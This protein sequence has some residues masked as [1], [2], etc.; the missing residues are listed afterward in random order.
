MEMIL[1]S[2]VALLPSHTE[3]RRKGQSLWNCLFFQELCD[4]TYEIT[5]E[6]GAKTVSSLHLKHCV[7]TYDVF[8]FMREVV[9]KVPD[10]G[11]AQ[12]QGQG[13]ATMYDRSISKKRCEMPISD[14]VNDSDEEY[15]KSKTVSL[16]SSYK[17]W[18]M[19]SP[20]AGVVEGDD[21][22]EVVE[23]ELLDRHGGTATSSRQHP[24]G[25]V[26]VI[27]TREREEGCRRLHCRTKRR[28][29]A[30]TSESK[31]W[32]CSDSH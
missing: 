6:R 2:R 9:S 3:Q 28:H 31:R 18:G 13:N 11:Q 27:T 4:R 22:K 15:K 23:D 10:Y 21:E 7:E 26:S 25:R 20:V 19:L 24:G 5:L 30:T 1:P 32:H 14:E 8:D 17:R 12:G 16:S 29:Q